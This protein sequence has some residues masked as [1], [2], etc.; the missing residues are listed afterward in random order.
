MGHSWHADFTTREIRLGN[1]DC[2]S[3][4]CSY[5]KIGTGPEAENYQGLKSRGV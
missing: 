5:L 3:Q 1:I 4:F 2:N